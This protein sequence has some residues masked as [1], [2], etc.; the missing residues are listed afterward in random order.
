MEQSLPIVQ[1]E[2]TEGKAFGQKKIV[3]V[4]IPAKRVGKFTPV[5]EMMATY[6]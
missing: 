2:A 1:Q 4:L 6:N 3:D 5:R